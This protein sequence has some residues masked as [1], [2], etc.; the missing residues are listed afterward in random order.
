MFC[1]DPTADQ[2]AV[3]VTPPRDS[4]LLSVGGGARGWNDGRGQK[5]SVLLTPYTARV[6]LRYLTVQDMYSRAMLRQTPT[7]IFFRFFF[8]FLVR[9]LDAHGD[10]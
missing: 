9:G 1:F 4:C 7:S 3:V 6:S 5:Y 2:R 8:D 10:Q